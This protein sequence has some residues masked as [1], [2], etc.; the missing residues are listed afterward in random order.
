MLLVSLCVV[1]ATT[2]TQGID[3]KKSQ[4]LAN[5]ETP[6]AVTVTE[7]PSSPVEVPEPASLLLIGSGLV[8]VATLAR[9]GLTR[10]G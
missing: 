10:R 4:H 3:P 8:G 5:A 1:A 7:K 6:M 2:R 9:R